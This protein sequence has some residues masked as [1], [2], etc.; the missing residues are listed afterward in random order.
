MKK[1]EYTNSAY[2]TDP[3]T[4]SFFSKQFPGITFYSK[5]L[6]VVY[7]SS[8]KAKRGQYGYQEWCQ[9]SFDILRAF[10]RTGV[11]F[12]ITGINYIEKLDTPCV[13]IGNHMSML[14]TVVLP[15]IIRPIRNM[16]FI[17]KQALLDYPVFKHV[18][19]ST[20]PIAVSRTNPRQDLKTVLDEGMD[21]LK[22]G[23][24]IIVF[25]Q[26]TRTASF[27]PKQF[28]TL[29][30]K[31]AQRANVPIIPL[32][33]ITDA[34]RNGKYIKDLGRIDTTKEV[35]FAFGEPII[36]QGRGSEEH[37]AVIDFINSKMNEWN[38]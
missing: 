2:Q 11:N 17:V 18:M 9:S 36:I 23:I 12:E 1:L 22:R 25:P 31:L 34:W 6:T 20:E 33:L 15:I 13:V 7:R 28:S 38:K 5:F 26:T 10:E 32:A 3:K 21:K 19:R 14:E 27:D 4:A 24:S 30:V 16:T 35:K 29:G 37:Q 8:A